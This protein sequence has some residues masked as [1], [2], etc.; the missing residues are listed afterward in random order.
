MYTFCLL[1]WNIYHWQF[2]YIYFVAKIIINLLF[3][4]IGKYE[5]KMVIYFYYYMNIFK[6]LSKV[7]HLNKCTLFNNAKT[8]TRCFFDKNAP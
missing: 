5:F 6:L 3:I 8:G 2:C 4:N 7:T 1:Y